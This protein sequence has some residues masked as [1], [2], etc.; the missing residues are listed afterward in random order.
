MIWNIRTKK[1]RSKIK[2]ALICKN[3]QEVQECLHHST[4]WPTNCEKH[5]Q[6]AEPALWRRTWFSLHSVSGRVFCELANLVSWQHTPKVFGTKSKW[7]VLAGTDEMN[8]SVAIWHADIYE[9]L[10]IPQNVAVLLNAFG[11]DGCTKRPRGGMY[12]GTVPTGIQ[13]V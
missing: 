1:A 9:T 5:S 10:C 6:D 2:L 4:K 7:I 13:L 12:L 3:Q 11:I 8:K